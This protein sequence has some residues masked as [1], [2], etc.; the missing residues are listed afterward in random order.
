[1]RAEAQMSSRIFLS[2][3][4]LLTVAVP[5]NSFATPKADAMREYKTLQKSN[6]QFKQLVKVER[7][8]VLKSMLGCTLSCG[9]GALVSDGLLQ[10]GADLHM[11]LANHA[12]VV[13]SGLAFGATAAAVLPLAVAKNA[14]TEVVRQA[15]DQGIVTPSTQAHWQ[16]AGLIDIATQSPP[17]ED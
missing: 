8:H 5:V 17:R 13:L 7:R 6:P 11:T 4:L 9:L 15:V 10:T 3:A 12:T 1:M 14:R 16:H 2:I